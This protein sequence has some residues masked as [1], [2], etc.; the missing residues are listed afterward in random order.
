M[1]VAIVRPNKTKFAFIKA[2]NR[3]VSF[4][5]QQ[6]CMVNHTALDI[7]KQIQMEKENQ[8]DLQMNFKSKCRI[9]DVNKTRH[10]TDG[11]FDWDKEIQGEC[12]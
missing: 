3:T 7:A 9:S 1:S 2:L 6:V 12:E 4:Q 5:Y 8:T 11:P 10:R